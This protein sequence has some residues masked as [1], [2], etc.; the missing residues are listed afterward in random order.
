MRTFSHTVNEYKDDPVA[1]EIA[2][3]SDTFLLA[4]CIAL[5]GAFFSLMLKPPHGSSK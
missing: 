2:A 5:G 4:A 1:A 3:Y